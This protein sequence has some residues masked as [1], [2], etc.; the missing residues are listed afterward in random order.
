MP[1]DAMLSDAMLGDAMVAA[2]K[3]PWRAHAWRLQTGIA[4]RASVVVY[5]R[6]TTPVGCCCCHAGAGA[7]V[8]HRPK[9]SDTRRLPH[10][11]T[12]MPILH[13]ITTSCEPGPRRSG[14]KQQQGQQGQ[15]GAAEASIIVMAP[16]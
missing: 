3:L 7:G 13:I 6:D 8:H 4:F 11:L 2:E 10:P 15:A 12:G 14:C 16:K 5:F 1:C 9:P